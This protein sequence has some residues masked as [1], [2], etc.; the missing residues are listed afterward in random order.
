M[1]ATFDSEPG[2][3]QPGIDHRHRHDPHAGA[4]EPADGAGLPG[5]A[6]AARASPTSS[7]CSRAKA[8]WSSS[9][10]KTDIKNG[11]TYSKF[12]TA[13]DAPFTTFETVLPA[14]P[15]SV[16]SAYT[17]KPPRTTS[18]RT[19]LVMPTTIVSQGNKLIEQETP[20]PPLGCGGV[21]G[22]TTKKLTL[23]QRYAK[24]LKACRARYKHNKHKRARC[25]RKAHSHLHRQSHRRLPQ[26][27][28]AHK[29][30]AAACEAKPAANTKPTQPNTTGTRAAWQTRIPKPADAATAQ[31]RPRS[32]HVLALRCSAAVAAS[33]E[34]TRRLRRLWQRRRLQRTRKSSQA[35][36]AAIGKASSVDDQQQEQR[37]EPRVSADLKLTRHGGQGTINLVGSISKSSC[38]DSVYVKGSP[39]LYQRLGVSL[40]TGHMGEGAR[41]RRARPAAAFTDLAGEATRIIST[42]GNVTKGRPRSR[43]RARDRTENRRQT[44]QRPPLH[45]DDRRTLPLKLEKTGRETS[46]TTFTNW[47]KTPPPTAPATTTPIT[48]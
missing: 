43:R 17:P 29:S 14:G 9:T 37:P 26:D 28:Q 15:K 33:G 13:P 6:R 24:A 25:E 10:G 32:T 21:K 4:E 16:L 38:G 23:A 5:L 8:S 1:E 2:E 7:S 22:V 27:P 3:L 44:L 35:S 30:N 11:I 34:P 20:I 18:A 31:P 47:N 42:S 45:Q 41:Q 19:K 36:K 40:P 12:E 39:M 46:H 48:K